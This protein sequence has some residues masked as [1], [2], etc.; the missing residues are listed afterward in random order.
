M[1]ISLS[2]ETVDLCRPNDPRGRD[3]VYLTQCQVPPKRAE[4]PDMVSGDRVLWR[5]PKR[6]LA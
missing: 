2:V 5:P 4:I 6:Y 3:P 1:Q